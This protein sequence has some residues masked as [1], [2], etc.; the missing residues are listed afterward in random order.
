M[1]DLLE[2]YPNLIIIEYEIYQ[3]QEVNFRVFNSRGDEILNQDLKVNDFGTF[4][5]KLILDSG[6]PLGSYRACAKQHSCIYFDVLEYVPA[7]FEVNVKADKEEYVSKETAN[8]EIE[9]N[10]YFGVTLEGGEVS[11]TISSQ[12]YYFDRYKGEYFAFDKL[13][14]DATNNITYNSLAIYGGLSWKF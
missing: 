13:S 11:Y 4:D 3:D 1:N 6:V 2:D 7:P 9:A 10:Y 12:N 5:T 8:L 14:G